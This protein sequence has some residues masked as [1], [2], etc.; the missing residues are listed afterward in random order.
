MHAM[1]ISAVH[2]A[3]AGRHDL[4]PTYDEGMH[5]FVEPCMPHQ[6]IGAHARM[7]ADSDIS[8]ALHATQRLLCEGL[9]ERIPTT[10]RGSM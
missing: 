8:S 10:A 1:N 5:P 9:D 4:H 3:D 2:A 7:E 6:A